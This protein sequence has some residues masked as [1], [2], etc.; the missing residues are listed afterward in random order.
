[1]SRLLLLSIIVSLATSASAAFAVRLIKP[2]MAFHFGRYE[3]PFGIV[4]GWF[5]LLLGAV[6]VLISFTLFIRRL[7]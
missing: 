7:P 4:S 6:F 2:R 1:M 3:L 5:M